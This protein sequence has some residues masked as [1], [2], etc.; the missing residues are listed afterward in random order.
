MTSRPDLVPSRDLAVTDPRAAPGRDPAQRADPRGVTRDAAAGGPPR[1]VTDVT[2]LAIAAGAQSQPAGPVSCDSPAGGA[3]GPVTRDSL[4]APARRLVTRGPAAGQAAYIPSMARLAIALDHSRDYKGLGHV[5]RL[6]LIAHQDSNKHNGRG[7]IMRRDLI[8]LC[9]PAHPRTVSRLLARG[10]SIFWNERTTPQGE[11]RLELVGQAAAAATLR[12]LAGQHHVFDPDELSGRRALI[13]DDLLFGDYKQFAAAAFKGWLSVQQAARKRITLKLLSAAWGRSAPQLI[14][15]QHVAGIE[16]R[17]NFGEINCNDGAGASPDM[18]RRNQ[19]PRFNRDEGNHNGFYR[20]DDHGNLFYRF[21]RGNTLTGDF[22]ARWKRGRLRHI[23]EALNCAS[24]R[25]AQPLTSRQRPRAAAD[26][27]VS[28]DAG[29]QSKPRVIPKTNYEKPAGLTAREAARARLVRATLP[30]HDAASVLFR[31]RR[32]A[33]R[34]VKRV[35]KAYHD[36]VGWHPDA[37]HYL[38]KDVIY[39]GARL[40]Q[41]WQCDPA[42]A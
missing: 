24:D 12:S 20:R 31:I 7:W 4:I 23:A 9:R 40:I 22:R 1:E 42:R 35:L 13:A 39:R 6:W 8:D 2:R 5:F 19:H 11:I 28:C 32:R 14:E 29:H 3:P 15:W 37:D 34:R 17:Q 16:S 26:I 30:P 18:V 10:S 41:V 38:L 36:A 33:A 25:G 27:A 21:Q